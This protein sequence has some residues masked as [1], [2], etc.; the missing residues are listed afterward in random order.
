MQCG[1]NQLEIRAMALQTQTGKAR[2]RE[3]HRQ[4][5]LD[6]KVLKALEAV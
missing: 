3:T 5:A 4:R 2:V 6:A 1:Q